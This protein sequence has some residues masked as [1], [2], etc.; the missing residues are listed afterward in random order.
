MIWWF[1]AAVLVAVVAVGWI[2]ENRVAPVPSPGTPGEYRVRVTRQGDEIASYN[3]E[4][5]RAVGM[6]KVVLQGGSEEGPALL[7]VLGKSG[8]STF[9]SL[10]IL[11]TGQRDSGRLELKA[12]DVGS[13]TVLDIAKRGTVKI[14]G[15]AIPRDKRVR[16]LT[17]IQVR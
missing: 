13:D 17:E 8:V 15:P 7:D 16:D 6:K 12:A 5:L 3:I 1:V 2:L 9:D 14:A 4:Q 11:G 10:T